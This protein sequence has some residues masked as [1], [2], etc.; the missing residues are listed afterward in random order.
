M[1]SFNGLKVPVSS[2]AQNTTNRYKLKII[3]CGY[4]LQ[5]FYGYAVDIKKGETEAAP[6]LCMM[7]LMD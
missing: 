3:I 4:S 1:F 5:Y 6:L 2:C 7:K